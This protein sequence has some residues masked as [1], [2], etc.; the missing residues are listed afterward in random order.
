VRTNVSQV[1]DQRP[2]GVTAHIH[3]DLGEVDKIMT[4]AV[5][6]GPRSSS[7]YSSDIHTRVPS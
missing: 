2:D 1:G 6:D 7:A 4:E 5:E 3:A